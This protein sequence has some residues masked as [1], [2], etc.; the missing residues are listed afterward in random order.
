MPILRTHE[1]SLVAGV[2]RDLPLEGLR[3]GQEV[4]ENGVPLVFGHLVV[5]PEGA[6]VGVGT[7]GQG[8][9]GRAEGTVVLRVGQEEAAAVGRD[10]Q[11]HLLGEAAQREPQLDAVVQVVP[12]EGETVNFV[13]HIQ[14]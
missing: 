14:L 3:L 2:A 5:A 10:A 13:G 11:H 8:P 7:C 9:D 12:G 4:R 6:L 1:W